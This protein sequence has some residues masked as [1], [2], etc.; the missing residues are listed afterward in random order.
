MR[1]YK[2]GVEIFYSKDG[3]IEFFVNY[4]SDDML[5]FNITDDED[6]THNIQHLSVRK[7]KQLIKQLENWVER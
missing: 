1:T 2:E 6:N 5:S 7:V 3:D 4:F